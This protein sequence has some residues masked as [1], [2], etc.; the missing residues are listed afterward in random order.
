VIVETAALGVRV[1]RFVR[2][3]L[4]KYLYEDADITLSPLFREIRH[5]A[6]ADLAKGWTLVVNLSLVEFFPTALYRCLLSIRQCVLARQCRLLLCG[7]NPEHEEILSLFQ[8]S[9]LFSFVPAETDA[10]HRAKACRAA[11]EGSPETT[12]CQEPF[13]SSRSADK[14]SPS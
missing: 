1:M 8:A 14:E 12:I 6:L 3:N 5:A 9:R 10:V 13:N 4:G 7:V 2:P 11:P